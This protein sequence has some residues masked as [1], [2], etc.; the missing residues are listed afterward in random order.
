MFDLI[1]TVT[2]SYSSLVK[3]SFNELKSEISYV[4]L[5]VLLFFSSFSICLFSILSSFT[6]EFTIFV[7]V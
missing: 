3:A 5:A 6:V 4:L 7:V 2:V 1:L